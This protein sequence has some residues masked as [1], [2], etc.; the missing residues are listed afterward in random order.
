MIRSTL[1]CA[2]CFTSLSVAQTDFFYRDPD[3]AHAMACQPEE[4]QCYIN[5]H[6]SINVGGKVET[7]LALN[8]TDSTDFSSGLAALQQIVDQVASEGRRIKAFGSTWSLSNVAYTNDVMV[9]SQGLTYCKVGI[10]DESHVTAAY[11]DIRNRLA[12]VQA[13]M[14]VRDVHQALKVKNLA[15]STT[16]AG[17]GQRFAGAIS[18]GTHGSA[19]HY[20]A[21]QEFV[22]ALHIVIPGEHVLLQRS[23]DPVITD[24]FGEWMDGARVI[25]DDT[26]FNAAVV[27]FGS[28]GIIHALIIEAE[29]LYEL[30]FQSK[31]FNYG[32]IKPVLESLDPSSLGFKGI[33]SE[34]PFHF[35][36]AINPYRRNQ[37]GCFVRLFEK[38]TLSSEEFRVQQESGML[39]AYDP[40]DT[41]LF[42]AVGQAFKP[43]MGLLLTPSLRRLVFGRGVQFALRRVFQTKARR[44]QGQIKK[45]Y[46]WFTFKGAHDPSTRSP[47]PGTGLE[48]GVPVDRVVEAIELIFAIVDSDP[49][50]AP[51]AIRFIKKS[52]AT[53]AF[54]KYDLTASIEISGP[55]DRVAFRRQI[56]TRNQIFETLVANGIPHTYHWGQHFPV[57]GEWVRNAFGADVDEWKDARSN[58]LGDSID[59]FSNDLLEHLGLYP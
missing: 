30:K 46:E 5:W 34:L 57:N 52:R 11:K 6:K 35:E 18:T 50:A 49:L 43:A 23:S 42:E 3:A 2:I 12:I 16:G 39:D 41:D 13:G 17:D 47:V 48:I 24:A 54:T 51:I 7:L 55:Y 9:N 10:D 21:M 15:L 37:D 14:M 4:D 28:F 22:R 19:L 56:K 25:S 26:L 45:P 33:G 58:F 1:L 59:I 32:Q 27:S 53:L 20:G 36:I 29:P 31:Q 40:E 44:E 38:L 8:N